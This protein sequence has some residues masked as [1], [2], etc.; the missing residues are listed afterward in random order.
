MLDSAILGVMLHIALHF[1]VPW[2]IAY[3]ADPLRWK[4][5]WL[6]MVSTM[7]VDLD[8][9]WATP[10]YDSERC[11]IDF[12]FLHQWWLF[13]MYFLLAVY[14]KSRWL[15]LGLLVHMLLDGIDCLV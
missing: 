15:G 6:L 10:V 13:P 7:L 1:V 11:S 9:L 5:P 3:R 4:K 12:H 8:H 14:P 2:L